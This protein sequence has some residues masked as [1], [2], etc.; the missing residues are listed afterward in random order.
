MLSD[1]YSWIVCSI[2]LKC[3]YSIQKFCICVTC[4]SDL[5]T[6]TV[7]A[8]K[9][10]NCMIPISVQFTISI[11]SWYDSTSYYVVFTF[12]WARLMRILGREGAYPR[13]YGMFFK[14]VVQAVLVLGL[15]TWVLTPCMERSLVSF[16]H[17][18]ARRITGRHLRRRR[19]GGLGVSTAGISYG[20]DEIWRDQ[21][22]HPKEAEYV[23]AIYFDATNYGPLWSIYSE[24]GG[25]VFLEVLVTGISWPSGGKGAGG[26]G[27]GLRGREARRGGGAGGDAGKELKEGGIM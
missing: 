20:G 14:V 18:F 5:A 9:Y 8:I 25:M 11:L 10:V 3:L 21:G 16:Q 19:G 17:R 13:V 12:S 2:T 22:L 1:T 15:E 26:G 24:A 4:M 23:C 7:C 6:F 27:D